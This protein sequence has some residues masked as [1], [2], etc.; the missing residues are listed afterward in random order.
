MIIITL[1]I[2]AEFGDSVFAGFLWG[3]RS[4]FPVGKCPSP[5]TTINSRGKGLYSV[6]A[7]KSCIAWFENNVITGVLIGHYFES[8][9]PSDF[10]TQGTTAGERQVEKQ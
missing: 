5:P 7:S 6:P 1:L 10:L 3:K 8:L 2:K 4:A 9:L